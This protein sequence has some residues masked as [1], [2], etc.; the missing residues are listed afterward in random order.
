MYSVKYTAHCCTTCVIIPLLLQLMDPE[1][2]SLKAAAIILE[3]TCGRGV[4]M[5]AQIRRSMVA[6]TTD[7]MG[8]KQVRIR[9]NVKRKTMQGRSDNYA[10]LDKMI[11]GEFEVLYPEI[12]FTPFTSCF[13][14]YEEFPY[15]DTQIRYY[16]F[17]LSKP[18]FFFRI[19]VC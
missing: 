11:Y 3:G 4:T 16:F 13:S 10:P 2:L 12:L 8:R 5:Q 17:L 19:Y 1:E 6:I 14:T 7:K 15:R 9:G 18:Q